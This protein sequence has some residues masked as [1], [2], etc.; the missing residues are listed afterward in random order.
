MLVIHGTYHWRARRIAFR[1][2]FCRSCAGERLSVLIRTL[3]VLHVFWIPLI[4]LGFW[5]RWFCA[6][7]GSRPHAV[8]RTRRGI[9]VAGAIAF[10]GM[11]LLAW[12]VPVNEIAESREDVWIAWLMRIG[13]PLAAIAATVSS[14]KQPI[15]PRFKEVLAGVK[16][17]EGWTCP[18]CQGQ[19]FNVPSWHC[20]DCRA[21]HR[22][23]PGEAWSTG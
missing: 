14:L 15:E 3:D 20:M 12:A 4:P 19:M 1:N 17:V 7:C 2:D 10:A 6:H 18:L 13:F 5:N 22:P 23:L 8:T 9:K 11:G 16:P 21:E